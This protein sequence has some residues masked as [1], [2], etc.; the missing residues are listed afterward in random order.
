MHFFHPLYKVAPTPNPQTQTTHTNHNPW[1]H[2]A[3]WPQQNSLRCVWTMRDSHLLL[4]AAAAVVNECL[5]ILHFLY[6]YPSERTRAEYFIN[7][8]LC[9]T[10]DLIENGF[11]AHSLDIF[12]TFIYR[13]N[14]L[15]YLTNKIIGFIYFKI[16]LTIIFTTFP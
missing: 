5:T 3:D 15:N 6:I 10:N 8:N 9:P 4:L 11:F 1:M 7:A 14:A 13:V 16:K 2:A 12:F